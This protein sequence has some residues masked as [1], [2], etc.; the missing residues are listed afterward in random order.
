M[1]R[2]R[3]VPLRRGRECCGRGQRVRGGDGVV[4]NDVVA[5]AAIVKYEI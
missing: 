1:T 4:A 2:V 5:D 3:L